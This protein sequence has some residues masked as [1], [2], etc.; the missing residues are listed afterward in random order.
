LEDGVD[1]DFPDRRHICYGLTLA[2]FSFSIL[3]R[4]SIFDK[5]CS[6]D[7]YTVVDQQPVAEDSVEYA[8]C[9][10]SIEAAGETRHW[11]FAM[12]DADVHLLRI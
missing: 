4:S 9:D 3:R 7:V 6:C 8:K 1:S 12:K 5:R 2:P 10:R 11:N